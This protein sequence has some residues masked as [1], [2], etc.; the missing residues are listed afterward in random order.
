MKTGWPARAGASVTEGLG[1]PAQRVGGLLVRRVDE[2]LAGEQ[3]EHRDGGVRE[4][5]VG[6]HGPSVLGVGVQEPEGDVVTLQEVAY[7]M[8]PGRCPLAD[9]LDQRPAHGVGLGPFGQR[10]GDDTVERLVRRLG[11]FGQVAVDLAQGEGLEDRRPRALVL[12]GDQQHPLGGGVEVVGQV[13]ELN[14]RHRRHPQVGQ[15]HG[16]GAAAVAEAPEHVQRRFGVGGGQH[17]VVGAVPVAEG[18][19][20]PGPGVALV[21]DEEQNRRRRTLL[22]HRGTILAALAGSRNVPRHGA[23]HQTCRRT[24]NRALPCPPAA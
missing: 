13:E 10:F 24:R 18:R 20:G 22:T 9:D 16:D 23:P 8:A 14:A 1:V 17:L 21:V 3:L 11:R 4:A 15:H 5:A 7:L 6:Q 12:P 19:L 2:D